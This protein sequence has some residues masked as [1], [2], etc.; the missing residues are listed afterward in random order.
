M[1]EDC[2]KVLN[3]LGQ[4]RDEFGSGYIPLDIISEKVKIPIDKLYDF[5]N[6]QEGILN[7]LENEGYVIVNRNGRDDSSAVATEEGLQKYWRF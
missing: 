7:N 3:Y 5:D 6:F 4:E 2:K 1:N